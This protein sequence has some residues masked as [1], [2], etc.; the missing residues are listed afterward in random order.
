[1]LQ[2]PYLRNGVVV[3]EQ[4]EFPGGVLIHAR[5]IVQL[6][7][8]DICPFGQVTVTFGSDCHVWCANNMST[9]PSFSSSGQPA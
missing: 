4:G 9:Q 5:R 8:V 7:S 6:G 2:D 1:M 3:T